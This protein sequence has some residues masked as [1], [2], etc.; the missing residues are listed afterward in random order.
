MH[1][2]I[3]FIRLAFP[4]CSQCVTRTHSRIYILKAAQALKLA[5]AGLDFGRQ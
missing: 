2:T 1:L 3:Y 5:F 4:S